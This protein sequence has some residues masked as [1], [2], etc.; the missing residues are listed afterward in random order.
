MTNHFVVLSAEKWRRKADLSN[1][2]FS[3][4]FTEYPR[5]IVVKTIG[6]FGDQEVTP[7]SGKAHRPMGTMNSVRGKLVRWQ[8]RRVLNWF[9]QP[10]TNYINYHTLP[11]YPSSSSDHLLIPSGCLSIRFLFVVLFEAGSCM[12]PLLALN[13]VQPVWALN[14]RRSFCPATQ[15]TRILLLLWGLGFYHKVIVWSQA[16]WLTF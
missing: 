10:E 13:S 1:S 2:P 9:F 3:A 5:K 8:A 11:A 12:Q 4:V 14:S 16:W 7:V 15:S 6:C